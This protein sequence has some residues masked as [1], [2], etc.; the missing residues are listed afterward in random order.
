L[1][2]R[3][4]IA[5]TS[6]WSTNP[7]TLNNPPNNTMNSLLTQFIGPAQQHC[8]KLLTR[9]STEEHQHFRALLDD[10]QARIAAMPKTYDQD[11]LGDNAIA[12]LH[13]FV[14]GCDWWITEKDAETPAE[15]GQHQ[16][17][18]IANLGYGPE[19]G[20]IS[21]VE[22]LANGAEFDLYWHPKTVGQLIPPHP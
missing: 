1:A 14:G 13:Y 22:L 9:K 12:H 7:F 6:N 8:L 3:Y 17:F 20:Y 11:G 2:S 19:L 4:P 16:A 18:G 5:I 21:I 15:P 10:W